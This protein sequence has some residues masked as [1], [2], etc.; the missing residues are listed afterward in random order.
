VDEAQDAEEG[1][2]FAKIHSYDAVVLDVMLP[3][4]GGLQLLERWRRRAQADSRVV[5]GDLETEK[6]G[7]TIDT[8]VERKAIVTDP[9]LW[10]A[11]L[12]NLLGNAVS[13]APRG[14][15]VFVEASPDAWR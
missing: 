1:E 9:L 11:I 3:R 5:V 15:H 13:H 2:T 6:R 7:L 10:T 8:E 14:A 12:N 4:E